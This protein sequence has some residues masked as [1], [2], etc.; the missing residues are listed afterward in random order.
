MREAS[1]HGIRGYVQNLSDGR[2]EIWAQAHSDALEDF[3]RWVERGPSSARVDLVEKKPVPVDET[4]STFD[5][6]Y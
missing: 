1:K 4:L 3:L 2:V 5:V 6:R